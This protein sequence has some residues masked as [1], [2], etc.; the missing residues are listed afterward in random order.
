MLGKLIGLVLGAVFLGALAP[1]A[2]AAIV[3]TSTVGW[4]AGAI[5]LWGILAVVVCAAFVIL[6]LKEVGI[7]F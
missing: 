1:T 4:G 3:N 2:I 7:E 6:I 5:A